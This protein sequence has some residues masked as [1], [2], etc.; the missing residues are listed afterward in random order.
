MTP[1]GDKARPFIG[2]PSQQIFDG[3]V[4]NFHG[5]LIATPREPF[6]SL[7]A[8]AWGI[9]ESVVDDRDT[10]TPPFLE[11]R[12]YRT[13]PPPYFRRNT[14]VSLP[15]VQ[16]LLRVDWEDRWAIDKRL[17]T[18]GFGDIEADPE[19]AA[20]YDLISQMVLFCKDPVGAEDSTGFPRALVEASARYLRRKGYQLPQAQVRRKPAARRRGAPARNDSTKDQALKADWERARNTGVKKKDF[21]KDRGVKPAVLENAIDRARHRKK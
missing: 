8:E 7:A 5:R 6:G 13:G 4:Y 15:L 2:S 18:V 12:I 17:P 14:V 16:R 9:I 10:P 21:C 19:R 3:R 1:C 11:A 20:L